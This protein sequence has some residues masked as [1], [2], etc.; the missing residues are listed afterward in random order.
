MNNK[1]NRRFAY[2]MLLPAGLVV[3]AVVLYPFIYNFIISLSN[4]SMTNFHDWRIIGFGQYVKVFTEKLF[5]SV[6]A[7]TIVWTV[8]NVLFHVTIGVFLAMLLN[9]TLPGKG[10]FRT[11]LII[12]WAMPQ[13]IAALTWRGMFNYQYGA[14]NLIIT[15]Y[16]AM[17]PVEWLRSPFEAFTACIL[18]NI[19]FGFPFMMIIALGGLQSID[20]SLYEAAE[21]D[22]A[23]QW[24]QFWTITVPLLRPVMVPAIVLGTIW[25]FNNLNVM[26][27]VSNGGEPADST[28]ILVSYV[29]KAAFNLYRYGYAAAFS[30]VI[31][32]IL[33][34]FSIFFIRRTRGTE[35]AY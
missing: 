11:L 10:I 32:V 30:V 2:L 22:G 12:P 14:I 6:F 21:V 5:Y 28:H 3:A 33:L 26:W 15:Q 18:T 34:I 4:M 17:S 31:F 23:S 13:Y 24:R 9:R 20:K 29:Y 1:S 35:G 27:L 16:L 25:T 7:K 8:V 19:W